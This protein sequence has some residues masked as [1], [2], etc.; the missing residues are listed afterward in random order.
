MI[1]LKPKTGKVM[2]YLI[3]ISFA[4]MLFSSCISRLARPQIT[5]FIVD[6][7]KNPIVNWKV[8]EVITDK[9]GAFLLPEIRYNKFF[10]TEMFAMEAPP[11]M[12]NEPIIK[13]GFEQDAITMFSTWGGGQAKGAKSSVDTINLRKENQEFDIESMLKNSKWQISLNKFGDTVYMIKENFKELCKT[14][15]CHIFYQ[16][17]E[18]LT[19]N[20]LDTFGPKNLPDGIIRRQINLKINSD[21]TLNAT[22]IQQY[23]DKEGSRSNLPNKKNDTLSTTGI[24]KLIRKNSIEISTKNLPLIN[25]QYKMDNVDLYQF[26][27]IKK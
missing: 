7:N 1:N 24:W 2:R 21:N 11:L 22:L 18:S 6:Y 12:V 19:D 14:E 3:A 26:T 15:K 9:N 20:Y 27:L 17:Y 25:G 4:A 23:G 16:K 5:G 8:G 13:E 10:L